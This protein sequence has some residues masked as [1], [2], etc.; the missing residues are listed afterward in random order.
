M[1]AR[2]LAGVATAGAAS[3]LLCGCGAGQTASASGGGGSTQTSSAATRRAHSSKSATA[4]RRPSRAQALA[5]VREVNLSVGDLP[6]ASVE[7]KRS[8]GV[9][10]VERLEERR[11]G[12]DQ[13]AK[14][15]QGSSPRLKRGKEPEVERI[16]SSV[17]VMRSERTVASEFAS[18]ASPALRKCLARVLTRNLQD[19]SI[20]D[21]RWGRV[22]V[23]KLAVRAPGASRTAGLR[24]TVVLNLPLDEVS[25]PVYS[26]E[27]AFAVGPAEVTLSAFSATQPV[28]ATTEQELVS[29]LLARAQAQPL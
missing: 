5:F 14:L 8:R 6:E 17:E 21:A 27:M 18:V 29:L 3:A 25:V 7:A 11:C 20:S 24:I 22:T 12:L 13:G 2:W 1:T 19:K 26:D 4:P 28:P 16:S 15:V 10:A 9:S 23:S